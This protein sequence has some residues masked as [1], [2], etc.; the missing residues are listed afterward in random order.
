VVVRVDHL[1]AASGLQGT[2]GQFGEDLVG[3]HVGGRAG[4][5]LEDVNGEI[6]VVLSGSHFIVSVVNGL[7]QLSV[8]HPEL[9]V[10][11]GSRFLDPGQS[12]DV[13]ALQ[14]L[15]GNGE[16]LHCTLRM[17]AVQGVHGDADFSHLVMFN[18]ELFSSGSH[19]ASLG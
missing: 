13:R 4:T 3:V 1:V 12:L 17:R 11:Q 14:S 2:G 16:V 7:G 19:G 10:C 15:A 18:A 6:A 9:C 8:E 5:G